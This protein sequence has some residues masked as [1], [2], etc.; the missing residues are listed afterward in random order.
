[1]FNV[2][3]FDG[4]LIINSRKGIFIYPQCESHLASI[5][6]DT[7]IGALYNNVHGTKSLRQKLSQ[8]SDDTVSTQWNRISKVMNGNTFPIHFTIT[9]DPENS[10]SIFKFYN[11]K[12][13]DTS[14]QYTSSFPA[15]KPINLFISTDISGNNE[16]ID[17]TQFIINH[18]CP[19]SSSQSSPFSNL[20]TVTSLVFYLL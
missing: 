11:G 14:C 13:I 2:T 19:S 10:Q 12:N 1:M 3:D 9:N 18:N 16:I 15:N 4:N 20:Q 8:T 17:I 7:K 5:P 6:T